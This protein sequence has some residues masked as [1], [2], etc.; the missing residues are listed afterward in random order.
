MTG[1]LTGRGVL[2]WLL[3]FFG[4]I[5]AMNAWY[6]TLSVKTFRGEDE[7]LPYLQGITYNQTLAHRA[8]QRAMDWRA[9]VSL[10]RVETGRVVLRVVLHD[11]VG[12]PLDGLLLKGE[13]RHPADENRDH[14]LA[15][16]QIAPGIYETEIAQVTPGAWDAVLRTQAG[17]PFEVVKRVWLQ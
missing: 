16:K 14:P 4:V 11:A 9:E 5:M 17:V 2:I 13:L 1:T 8:E 12:H 7:Q 6:I 3:G 10:A 15:M